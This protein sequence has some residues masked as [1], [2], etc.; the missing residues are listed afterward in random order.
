MA[1][2]RKDGRGPDDIRPIR[3]TRNYQEFAEGSCLIE[4]GNT[5]VLCAASHEARV[6]AFLRGSG[7]GW[8][9]AEYSLLPRST[10]VRTPR[11][12]Q[13]GRPSGRTQEIQRLI[14]RSLRAVT[15]LGA[16]G[17]AT[18]TV[19]CDVLLA[20]GG[21]RTAAITGGYVALYD[22]FRTLRDAGVVGGAPLV[23]EVAAVS[24]GI[25]NGEPV[26]DLAYEEDVA[27]SVDMNV[28]MT[29]GGRFVE[30]QGTAEGEPFDG[31]QLGRLLDLSASGIERLVR[32]QRDALGAG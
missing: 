18:I 8:V 9:T 14:G 19:D 10:A 17:E 5:R 32:A 23:A 4:L 21:T 1:G 31:E 16:F 27:A 13:A 20:D 29:G 22:A 2:A 24:V 12:V 11:E 26:L 30:V 3:I 6:P 15:D 7:R 28:V 25:L